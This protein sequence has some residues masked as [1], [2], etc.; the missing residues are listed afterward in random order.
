MAHVLPSAG[1]GISVPW[2]LTVQLLSPVFLLSPQSLLTDETMDGTRFWAGLGAG[3]G[4]AAERALGSFMQPFWLGFCFL[5]F[6][7]ERGKGIFGLFFSVAFTN[8]WQWCSWCIH[9]HY[10]FVTRKILLE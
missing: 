8:L 3:L 7:R 6:F 1:S 4:C 2:T 10:E 5:F 9:C